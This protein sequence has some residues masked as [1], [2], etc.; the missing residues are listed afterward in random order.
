MNEGE[1]NSYLAEGAD[2][3]SNPRPAQ[4]RRT[5]PRDGRTRRIVD[6]SADRNDPVLRF[7]DIQYGFQS[8]GM[9]SNAIRQNMNQS[10][11]VLGEMLQMIMNM[12]LHSITMQ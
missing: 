1:M 7:A 9:L 3:E 5:A 4:R 11:G 12:L 8:V 10:L 2:D 6:F